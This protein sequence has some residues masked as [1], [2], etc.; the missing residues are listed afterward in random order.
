MS[1]FL[2]IQKQKK[3]VVVFS[4]RGC[5]GVCNRNTKRIQILPGVCEAG[6]NDHAGWDGLASFHFS[7]LL[8]RGSVVVRIDSG[9]TKRSALFVAK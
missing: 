7:V 5:A 8:S 9:K 4:V 1:A 2:Q 6:F 3:Q